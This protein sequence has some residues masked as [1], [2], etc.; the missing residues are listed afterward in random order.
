MNLEISEIINELASKDDVSAFEKG[1]FGTKMGFGKHPLILVVDMTNEFVDPKYP[2]AY[3]TICLEA[4]DAI[5]ELLREARKQHVPIIYTKGLD[6]DVHWSLH[7]I[8]R[9]KL[10]NMPSEKEKGANEIIDIIAPTSDDIVLKKPKASPFFGTPLVTILSTLGIDTLIVT[11]ATTSGC[12]RAAVVDAASYGFYVTV[13]IE[14]CGDR[15]VISHKVNLM[16]MHMKYA[17]VVGLANVVQ[18]LS[19]GQ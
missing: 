15:S 12:V 17:D 3:G 19:K 13:P 7:G 9:K 6:D 18:Y 1:N 10:G 2:L 4:A 14:C 16:D 8:S 5:H 11:G